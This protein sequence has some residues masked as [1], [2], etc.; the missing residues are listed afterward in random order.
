MVSV[1]RYINGIRRPSA[2][3]KGR[4]HIALILFV[5]VVGILL[6][7]SFLFFQVEV[8]V[9]RQ[10]LGLMAGD[11]VIVNRMSY[12]LR[13]PF[14]DWLGYR[15][16]GKCHLEVGDMVVY[17]Y[18]DKSGRI[19]IDCVV[20]LPGDTLWL[21]VAKDAF[22]VIPSHAYGVGDVVLPEQQI[23]GKPVYISY[24][25]DARQPFYR[26]FRSK[27]FFVNIR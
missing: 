21:A 25:V 19:S 13:C 1:K 4:W 23:I 6:V 3:I 14:S 22:T 8:P 27:R 24:S 15:R 7:R 20:A 26:S 10:D 16:W 11:R 9:Q 2:L 18:P 17:D 5:A 12:G